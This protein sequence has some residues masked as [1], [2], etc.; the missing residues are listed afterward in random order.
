M[1]Q[2]ALTLLLSGLLSTGLIA[3]YHVKIARAAPP[4]AVVDVARVF[5]ERQAVLTKRLI[6][7]QSDTERRSI[8]ET[9]AKRFVADVTEA[10]GELAS[11]CRCLVLDKTVLVGADPKTPDLTDDL[12][13]RVQ[14]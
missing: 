5:E 3:A 2:T 12:R 14:Q 13:K 7:S 10:M 1:K 8:V 11:E 6:A 9:E 4:A